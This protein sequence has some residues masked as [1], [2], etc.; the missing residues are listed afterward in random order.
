MLFCLFV[1]WKLACS[2]AELMNFVF[3]LNPEEEFNHYPPIEIGE[4]RTLSYCPKGGIA[5]T[6]QLT[7]K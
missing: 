7:F 4:V 1:D 6:L 3:R 2:G 5:W